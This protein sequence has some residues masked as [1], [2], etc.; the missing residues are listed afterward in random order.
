MNAQHS[1]NLVIGITLVL[2]GWNNI[3]IKNK[4]QFIESKVM[5]LCFTQKVECYEKLK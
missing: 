5:L 1:I 2:L 4:I 3:E